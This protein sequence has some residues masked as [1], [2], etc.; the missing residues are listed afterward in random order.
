MTNTDFD[1]TLIT[2]AFR[3]AAEQGWSKVNAV[4]AARA[5]GLPL[6][7]ARARF[8][9]RASILLRF[10][11]QADRQA[12]EDAASEGPVRDRLFDLLMRRI[13]TLQANR[14]GV[15]ALL[16]AL[17]GDPPTALL[18]ACASQRSMRWMLQA[19]GVDAYGPKGEIQIR[20]LMAV[21]LWAV[22]AWEKD[23]SEDLS[24]TMAAVDTALGRAE[25]LAAW[26][27]VRR[28]APPPP[29]DA[30]AGELD[31]DLPVE[32]QAS[33]PILPDPSV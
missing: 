6:A 1:S 26:L 12:L 8:P 32:P 7:K 2:A 9:S 16:R 17:P 28:P 27:N 10:G 31:P 25:G 13:D 4:S 22:R 24:H 5:A 11:A 33:G 14:E 18:L 19:A 20:G 30:G 23:N 3:L 29:V 15:R 21:W